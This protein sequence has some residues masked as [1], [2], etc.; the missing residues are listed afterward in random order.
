M[1]NI[2]LDDK[3]VGCKKLGMTQKMTGLLSAVL[4]V[5]SYGF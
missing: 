5:M 3:L 2:W 1:L 4:K